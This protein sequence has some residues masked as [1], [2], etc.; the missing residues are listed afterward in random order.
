MF[1]LKGEQHWRRSTGWIIFVLPQATTAGWRGP[2]AGE[3]RTGR[4][5]QRN[6]DGRE[7]ERRAACSL[8]ASNDRLE[9]RR[10]IPEKMQHA[11]GKGQGF[12]RA[13]GGG[14]G[15]AI[16]NNETSSEER[17]GASLRQIINR[18]R[19]DPRETRVAKPPR[20]SFA[21]SRYV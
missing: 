13:G 12:E 4:Q 18:A 9:R 20:R 10:R 2:G 6:A 17:E 16:I 15:A 5:T 7:K 19:A 3:R 21:D 14:G 11:G 8:N 1:H